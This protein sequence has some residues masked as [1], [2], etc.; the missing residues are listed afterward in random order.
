MI[1]PKLPASLTPWAEAL[2]V[3]NPQL[4]V[5]IGPLVRHLDDMVNRGDRA[6]GS[7]GS[8][9]G[10]G[11]LTR[12]GTPERI[13]ASQWALAIELPW[14]FMRRA[15]NSELLFLEPSYQQAQAR[16]RVVALAD[17]GPDQL[18]AGRLV[19]LA[20]L[21]VL[22][23]RAARRGTELI[24]GVLGDQPG[25]WH[26]GP[27]RTVLDGWLTS[28][29]STDSC[30]A[31]VHDWTATVD[32]PDEV[33]LLS[34]PRLAAQLPGRGRAVI[35]AE[36]AWTA[37]GASAVNV[38]VDGVRTELALPHGDVAVRALRGAALRPESAGTG[39]GHRLR[40]AAFTGGAPA[41]LA[42]G[43]DAADV[44]L[45]G[46]PA[47]GAA[48]PKLKHHRF[49]GPV[50]TAAT[51]GRR[52]VA[53]VSRGDEV[54]VEVHGKHL[55]SVSD[56]AVRAEDIGLDRDALD[57]VTAN[58]FAPLVY[59]AG[60]LVTRVEGAW[61]WLSP[62][63]SP[64]QDDG[65]LAVLPGQLTDQPSIARS[66]PAGRVFASNLGSFDAPSGPFVLGAGRLVAWPEDDDRWHV[67]PYGRTITIGSG[68]SVLGLQSMDD[69]PV[70]IT[71]SA[72]GLIT[73]L[74]WPAAERTL[75]A[76]SGGIAPPQLHP[77]RAWLAVQ[78]DE[79]SIEVHDLVTGERLLHLATE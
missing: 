62:E 7:H 12:R 41:L 75:T 8:L 57:S 66:G 77:Q 43:H 60:D 3:L 28:R 79:G 19:Q 59:F 45:I 17:C 56:I 30:G 14:E 1:T 39:I 35:S 33:W 58:A 72:G 38:V 78:P 76:L 18:G 63:E 13:L 69:A 42:R 34:G 50:L 46:V 23:R 25:T 15:A 47:A 37:A 9:D 36:C 24:L 54:H 48:V 20:T 61:W 51:I 44:V 55:G 5:A 40:F 70:L 31:D 6:A 71:V 67:A 2:A 4:A 27:P 10:Y 21:I 73:R 16:G 32:D 11:G 26:T 68:E 52:V 74:R 64:R 22:H 53:L 65:I 49:S 29:R